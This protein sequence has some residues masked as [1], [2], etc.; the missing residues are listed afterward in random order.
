MSAAQIFLIPLAKLIHIVFSAYFWIVFARAAVSWV[1][2]DPY[3]PVVRFLYEVTEPP[4]RFIR[5][6]LPVT[7]R[8]F[9]FSPIV[10]LLVLYFVQNI[11]VQTLLYAGA[12]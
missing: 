10:L 11:I 6:K 5:R 4:L 7:Y 2:A 9:D 1:N 12:R 8:G 3:N